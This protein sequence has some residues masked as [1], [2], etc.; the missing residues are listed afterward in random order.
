MAT[1]K[2]ESGGT[3]EALIEAAAALIAERGF[4]TVT[5]REITG[6]AGSNIASVKY[7]FGSKEDLIDAVVANFLAPVNLARLARIDELEAKGE[8]S[9]EDLLRAFFEPMLSQIK[10]SPLGEKLFCQLMGRVIGER[11]YEFPEEVMGQF[12]RV[13]GRFVPA[14][15]K[16]APGLT[17]EDVFWRIHFSFGVMSNMLTHGEILKK[18]TDGKVGEE[19]LEKTMNRVIRFCV[20][21]FTQGGGKE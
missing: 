11:T 5:V 13:A 6:K 7:H 9:V 20:A 1:V 2:K 3:K 12:R 19:Q 14:F 4:E 16:A 17:E 10:E 21:G 8:F 15:M 18:V